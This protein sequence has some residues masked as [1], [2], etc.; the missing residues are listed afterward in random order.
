M[1]Y[2]AQ[3]LTKKVEKY[4]DRYGIPIG[5]IDPIIRKVG[6]QFHISAFEHPSIP[7]LLWSESINIQLF[8]WGIVPSWTRG[9]YAT[10]QIRNKT[11][12][13]RSETLFELPSFKESA[14]TK[15]CIVVF[16]GFFEHH[17]LGQGSYPYHI[18]LANDQPMSLAGIWAEWTG[19]DTQGQALTIKSV[20]IITTK[21]NDI[22][23]QIHNNPKI[24]EAR[25]PVILSKEE[26]SL[27]LSF[28]DKNHKG[29]LKE[30]FTPKPSEILKVK[31]VKPLSGKSA[32]PNTAMAIEEYVYPVIGLPNY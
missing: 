23:A 29:F 15:R 16:D 18:E 28:E 5:D 2:N 20:S 12:N 25:M 9:I 31:T 13:A 1:C 21:A 22:M 17:H 24:K 6:N 14:Y 19:L 7:V 27:W 11:L 10:Q 4:A 8:N 30:V 3:Y 32:S 26:E